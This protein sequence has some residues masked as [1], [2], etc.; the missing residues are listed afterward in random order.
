MMRGSLSSLAER[1]HLRSC[2]ASTGLL[3]HYTVYS[4]TR[5]LRL[6]SDLGESYIDRTLVLSLRRKSAIDRALARPHHNRS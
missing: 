4:P 1:S 2:I 6:R 5:G 3:V